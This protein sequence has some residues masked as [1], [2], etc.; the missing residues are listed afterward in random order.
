MAVLSL[1]LPAAPTA[2][3][4]YSGLDA[5]GR[6]SQGESA[7]EGTGGG[8]DGGAEE[9][10]VDPE[11]GPTDLRRLTASQYDNTVRDLLGITT[12]ASQEF[13]FSPDER[14]GPFKSNNAAPVAGLQVEQYMSAA[15]ALA[16][17][18][19]LDL[20]SL[21]PC[22]PGVVGEQACTEQLVE[23]LGLRAYRR[24][25]EP[26]EID[27]LMSVYQDG[28]M[29]AD[30]ADGIRLVVQAML[31]SPF[32][33]Y[34]IEIGQPLPDGPADLVALDGYEVASRLSYFLWDTMPD[35]A[36]FEAAASGELETAEGLSAQ[37]DRMLADPK[38]AD[39]IA[40][41]HL[42][43][44]GVDETEGLEKDASVF[45]GFDSAL[46]EAMKEETARFTNWVVLEGDGRL[47]TLLT[48][49][50]TV[51]EDPA[52]LALYGATLPADHVPGDPV[53]LPAG[54]RSGLLTHPSVL[55]SHSHAN[56]TSPIHR[57]V[58]VRQNLL[59]Q[60]LPPPPPDVDNVPPDP[61][62]DATTRE[63]FDQHT[64]DPACAG[65]HDLIDPVGFGLENY[66][67]IGA[68][69]TM[70]GELPVDASGE[71]LGTDVDGPF[72]GGLELAQ[73]LAQSRQV[74]ECVA[75]QW[76]R[77]AFGRGETSDDDCAMERLFEA[78][79]SSEYDIRALLREIVLSDAFRYRRSL[80]LE[81]APADEE[82]IR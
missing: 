54:E 67:G 2:S 50:F 25:L 47:E 8:A 71:L 43:W 69:R 41:F 79:E 28:R 70:E 78:F 68:F 3:G 38:A 60:I 53:D 77:F 49:D 80:A 16:A 48:A 15:E 26:D 31:Q 52:L 58:M 82:E 37:V 44:L 33:L 55:A 36:L 35:D 23:E 4:C 29:G 18:A 73:R 65:C 46:A 27:R 59:C 42:Q 32:F 1:L 72:D 6:D 62:P 39:A 20:E 12:S 74:R 75:R 81:A 17:D 24:P 63:R 14:V 56:Q 76:F 13:S 22:D 51:T 64:S 10:C 9:L 30:F 11:V 45:P 19:V 21:L 66:D 7:G 40:S 5:D 61:D 57:G 34:H